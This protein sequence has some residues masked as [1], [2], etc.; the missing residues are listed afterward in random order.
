LAVVLAVAVVPVNWAVAQDAAPITARSAVA[1][2][3]GLKTTVEIPDFRIGGTYDLGNRAAWENGGEGGVTLE[4][5]GAGPLRTS[6]IAVGTPQTDEEGKIVNAI[7]ISSYYSGDATNMYF[8]WFEG[9]GGNAFSGGALIG[10]GLMFDTD[11]FYIV[12]TDALGLWGAS[13]PSDGLGLEFPNY[14]Y[15]DMV[16]AN[17]RLLVDHLNIG[18]VVLATGVSMG[19]TQAYMWGLMHPEFVDAV[20]PI[21]GSTATDGTSPIAAWTFQNAKAAL[22]SDPIWVETGGDYYDLPRDQH[23]RQGSAFHWSVLTL[24]GYELAYRQSQGWDAVKPNVFAWDPPEEGFGATVATLGD[25][26]DAVDLKYRVEVGETHNINALLPEY[27]PRTLVIHIE[28]DMWLPID[29]ARD[30]VA[31]IPGAQIATETSP[32]AHYAVFSVLNR[33]GTNPMVQSFLHDIGV[34]ET[35]GKVCDAPGYTSPRVN[36]NPDPATSFWL[37]NMVHPF[38][39]QFTN[40]TDQNGVEWQIGYFDAVCEGIEDP[41]TLVVVHGKGAFA[42][43]YGYLIKFAVEQGYR[44][45]ALDMPHAGLSGPG[46][47]GKPFA[48]DFEDMRSAFH[49]V[50]VDQLGIDEAYYLGHSLGGQFVLGYALKYPEAVKGLILEAPAGLEIFPRTTELDG[51]TLAICDPAITHDFAAW[52]AAWGPTGALQSEMNRDEQ[53][54][55]DFFYFKERDPVTGAVSPSFFGYFKNDTEYARLHTDQRI[56]MIS[57]NP[58]ELEQWVIWFIYDIWTICSENDDTNPSPLLSRLPQIEAPIFLAFGAQEPFIPSTSLNGLDDMA[59]QVITPFMQSM[60]EAGNPVVAK[61]YPGVGHFIHTDEPYQFARDTVDFMRTGAVDAITPGV[62]DALVNGVAAPAVGG[63]GAAA[64]E[65]PS[66][67]S[68]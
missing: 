67:F 20:M 34:L 13:K 54:V 17:Y 1:D 14:T 50:I 62:V 18:H 52:E 53:S 32:I 30:S 41:E 58:E 57:G 28:N 7:V 4:S 33:M 10:P 21:G 39:P 46:N 26:F 5:L 37:D 27:Q 11:R 23:P 49:G 45:V 55:R 42:S 31:L 64:P 2:L 59:N 25:M 19:G 8:N 44:V 12:M 35:E 6:Y 51:Q 15:Y 60:A 16:Q 22:E 24:T 38:E 9:Q 65:R 68:K 43:H 47:L 36:M 66:G 29:K 56:A 40:V 3:D 61:I 48:R 63:G